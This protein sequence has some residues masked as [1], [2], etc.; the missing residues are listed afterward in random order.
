L[1][2]DVRDDYPFDEGE[3]LAFGCAEPFT[4]ADVGKTHTVQL[5]DDTTLYLALSAQVGTGQ[6]SDECQRNLMPQLPVLSA[7]NLNTYP[8]WHQYIQ[9]VYKQPITG[10][11]V[12]D[13]N[14]FSMFYHANDADSEPLDAVA[15]LFAENP[16]LRICTLESWPHRQPVYDGS[17][18][19][20]DS[21]PEM[22]MNAL[23][24]FVHREF[25]T[26]EEVM[27]CERLEVMH[28]RTVWL[29]GEQG[30]SWF[31]N[32]VGSGVF[33]DCHDLPRD[34]GVVVLR[35]REEWEHEHHREW[36]LDPHI[37]DVMEDEGSKLMVFTA[38]DFSVFDTDGTNPSTEIIVRHRD[39]ES[40]EATSDR[41]SCLDDDDI[42]IR[43]RTGVYGGLACRCRVRDP[44]L[45]SINCEDTEYSS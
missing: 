23:G 26:P 18:F 24:F 33:L 40:S 43:F 41:G 11:M 34:G 7:S 25:I 4:A 15:T 13:L 12:V 17:P 32:T 5:S 35:N 28:L 19:V 30:V 27:S 2:F 8:L 44:P 22:R 3:L 14:K 16:C 29:G 10:G 1:C 6:C 31:F 9:R 36:P 39:S 20:G 21:G 42:G 45:A 37:R 38:A